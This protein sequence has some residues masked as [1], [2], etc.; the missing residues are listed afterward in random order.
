[1]NAAECSR[2]YDFS[3]K[4]ALITG[5]TGALGGEMACALVGLGANVAVLD[6]NTEIPEQF[7]EPLDAG[8]GKYLVVH[9]DVLEKKLLET[10]VSRVQNA[11]G[12][13]DILINA[14]GGNH[15]DATTSTDQ[16][17]FDLPPEAL[18]FV[19]DLNILGTMLPSQVVGR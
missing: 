7:R 9:G 8:P 1:M 14:A 17:F 15:P 12:R 11:F 18:G 10:A 19:F 2:W 5:G 4:S 6:R 16:P 3:G 13:I